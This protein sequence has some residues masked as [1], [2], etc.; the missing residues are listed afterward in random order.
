MVREMKETQNFR[1]T[2]ASLRERFPSK[3]SINAKEL[4]RY[5]GQSEPKTCSAI[6]KG[7]LPGRKVGHTY[8]ITLNQL[9]HWETERSG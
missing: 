7:T 6:K 1:E 5:L 3:D 4:A 8:I 2:L 9:A